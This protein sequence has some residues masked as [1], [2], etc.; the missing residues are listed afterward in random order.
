MNIA[1]T[2]VALACI[3][4]LIVIVCARLNHYNKVEKYLDGKKEKYTFPNAEP[5]EKHK[6]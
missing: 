4:S 1:I 2:I 3:V 5:I 6:K